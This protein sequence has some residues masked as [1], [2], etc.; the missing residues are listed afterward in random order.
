MER[1][2][3]ENPATHGQVEVQVLDIVQVGNHWDAHR[4]VRLLLHDGRQ[5]QTS[6][7]R[8]PQERGGH[9]WEE[10]GMV[11]VQDLSTEQVMA[12]VDEILQAGRIEEAFEPYP[13]ELP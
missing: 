11:I 1:F 3:R 9:W 10:P 6:F 13:A 4:E 2:Q 8:D 5:Y 7:W 12:A